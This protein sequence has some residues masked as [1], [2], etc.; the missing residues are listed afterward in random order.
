MNVID[1]KDLGIKYVNLEGG[2]Y[3]VDGE[4]IK[5]EGY[6]SNSKVQVKDINNI[7]KISEDRIIIKYMKGEEEMSVDEYTDK[8]NKLLKNR[9]WDEEYEEYV[10]WEDLESEYE[11]K[12]LTTYWKPIYK[13]IQ[14]ISDPLKVAEVK[15]IIYDTNNKFIVNIFLNGNK[16]TSDIQL[17]EYRQPEARIHIVEEIFKSLGFTYEDNISYM[18]TEGRKVW[19]NSTHSGI[20]YVTAFGRFI[21]NDSWNCSYTP[22]GTIEDMRKKYQSDYD[23]IKKL[24]MTQYNRIYGRIEKES[25]DFVKLLDDLNSIRSSIVAVDSKVKTVEDRRKAI[26]KIDKLTES[27]NSMFE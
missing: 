19:S 20:R 6:R 4:V 11:Y 24:I 14:T 7:R 9:I 17:Y 2:K 13:D 18:R 27:I 25:F 21:F 26:S 15:E 23:N 10:G 16:D 12:K 8:K 3:L 5:I 22:R 1:I